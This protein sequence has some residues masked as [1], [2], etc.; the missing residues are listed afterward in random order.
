MLPKNKYRVAGVILALVVVVSIVLVVAKPR[1]PKGQAAQ[2]DE[3]KAKAMSEEEATAKAT[4]AEEKGQ[5]NSGT[6]S[7]NGT[8]VSKGFVSFLL[9]L[10]RQAKAWVVDLVGKLAALLPASHEEL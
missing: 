2:D 3:V 4:A 1:A 9:L 7:G 6:E 10:S 8:M 5:S